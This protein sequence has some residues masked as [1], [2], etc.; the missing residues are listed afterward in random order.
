M[1]FSIRSRLMKIFIVGKF[2]SSGNS[3]RIILAVSLRLALTKQRSC[4]CCLVNVLTGSESFWCCRRWG[5]AKD[6]L[7]NTVLWFTEFVGLRNSLQK[8]KCNL[9]V[10][11]QYK[12]YTHNI[13]MSWICK[14]K[15]TTAMSE[16]R[17]SWLIKLRS[18]VWR[19]TTPSD[20]FNNLNSTDERR[21]DPLPVIPTISP[22]LICIL[23]I[24]RTFFPQ[25]FTITSLKSIEMPRSFVTGGSYKRL[26][27]LLL[28]MPLTSW[29]INWRLHWMMTS[30]MYPST[31]SSRMYCIIK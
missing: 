11:Y 21:C 3:K 27:C 6:N 18:W 10:R 29:L 19:K 25:S 28:T 24:S 9:S 17:V 20:G 2:S 8:V 7:F 30:S 12:T 1:V 13:L 15:G 22:L 5:R 16:W 4:F 26:T 14:S 23:L 31:T